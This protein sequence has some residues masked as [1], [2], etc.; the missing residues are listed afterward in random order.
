MTTKYPGTS[1]ACQERADLLESLI[2]SI[3]EAKNDFAAAMRRIDNKKNVRFDKVHKKLRALS[4][5]TQQEDAL[6][7][8]S[9]KKLLF[10][11]G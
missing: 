11:G 6:H 2:A 7:E 8:S 9:L 4:L 1:F 10:H 5:C 3:N